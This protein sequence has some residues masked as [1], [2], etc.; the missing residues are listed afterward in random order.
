MTLPHQH[1]VP[2]IRQDWQ[3]ATEQA[4]EAGR[5]PLLELGM[6]RRLLN[7]LPRLHALTTW[8]MSRTDVS[9]PLLLTGDVDAL[10]P[11]PL[12]Y[13][14]QPEQAGQKTRQSAAPAAQVVYGGAD[15]A[16]YLASLTTH[17]PERLQRGALYAVDLPVAMQPL[18][19]P[20]TQPHVNATWQTI[21]L[22]LLATAT[23]STPSNPPAAPALDEPWLA[24]AALVMIIAL[25]LL[26]IFV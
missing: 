24:R 6:D 18:V 25:V 11:V 5:S 2:Q 14:T 3:Q 8:T 15:Q 19:N 1:T 7:N 21:P 12:L 23:Q 13:P 4:V 26:A 10:W 9:H 16:T 20:H 22:T 17:V